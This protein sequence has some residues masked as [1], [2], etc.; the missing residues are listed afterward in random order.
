VLDVEERKTVLDFDRLALADEESLET[1]GLVDEKL[2][3]LLADV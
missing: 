3:D 1:G 2:G